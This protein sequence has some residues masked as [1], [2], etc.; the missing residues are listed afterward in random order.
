MDRRENRPREKLKSED[1]P[2]REERPFL[3][4]A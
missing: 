1:R 3:L 4:F 2:E